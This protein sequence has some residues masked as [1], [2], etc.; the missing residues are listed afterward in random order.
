MKKRICALFLMF[1][2]SFTFAAPK[3]HADE[4]SN[5]MYYCGGALIGAGIAVAVFEAPDETLGPILG[6]GV[7]TIGLG[8]IIWGLVRELSVVNGVDA[9]KEVE[10][11]S[12]L[13]HFSLGSKGDDIALNFNIKF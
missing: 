8:L 7:G 11:N 9:F 10:D 2:L 5:T 4:V 1:V 3:L 13:K 6:A 12:V